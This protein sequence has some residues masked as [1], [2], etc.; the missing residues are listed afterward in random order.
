VT[1]TN[2]QRYTGHLRIKVKAADSLGI[3]R[4]RLFY[5]GH[6]I[7]N[8]VPY[9]TTHTYPQASVA[10]MTWYGARHLRTGRHLITVVAID[11]LEN[12]TSAHLVIV[13]LREG[14]RR[15]RRHRARH[16]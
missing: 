16:H 4:I 3:R 6:L 7:R 13:H 11:K 12:S 15:R 14:G 10:E 8:F 2:G 5:D 1:P 9:F